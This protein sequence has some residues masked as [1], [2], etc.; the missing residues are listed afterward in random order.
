MK[1]SSLY[2]KLKLNREG[3]KNM[4]DGRSTSSP[5][6]DADKDLLKKKKKGFP[7]ETETEKEKIEVSEGVTLDPSFEDIEKIQTVQRLG[8]TPHSQKFGK[9]KKK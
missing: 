6:Q 1:G 8:I 3:Y 7:S 4:P 2:G 9:I 5:F